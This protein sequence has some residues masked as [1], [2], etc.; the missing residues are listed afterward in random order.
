MV[1]ELFLVNLDNF[2]RGQY[3]KI[4]DDTG[5]RNCLVFFCPSGMVRYRHIN[6]VEPTMHFDCVCS[7]PI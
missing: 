5:Y 2:Y 3:L 6:T 4:I 7:S 1:T